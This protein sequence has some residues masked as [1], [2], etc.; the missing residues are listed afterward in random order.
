MTTVPTATGA[1]AGDELGV[2]LMHE[3]VFVLDDALERDL[4]HPEWDEEA[5]IEAATATF[6][7]LAA[8]GVGT[9]VDLTVPGLGRD[10]ARVRRV[11]SRSPVAIV[12]ATGWY[13]R[14]DLPPFFGTHGPGRLVGGADPLEAL[15]VRD[16][17]EGIAGTGVRAAVIKVV[18]DEPGLTPDVTRVLDAAAA[19]HVR[20]GAP[21]MTHSHAPTRGGLAQQEALAA[22]GVDLGRVVIGHAGD[23][24]DLDYLRM[25]ADR[26]SFLGFD[27]FGMAH[28]QSDDARVRTLLALLERGYAESIVLS[29]DAA[30]FS[31][32]TPP[33][34]RARETPDWRMDHLATRIVPRLRAAGV[35]DA[36]MR[37][38]QVDNPRRI[39]AGR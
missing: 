25:L 15:F 1:V 35:D 10:V 19:A 32:V 17:E 4:P 7:R 28:T 38:M 26:G 30:V 23:S 2:T 14:G 5:A 12:V 36:T 37:T 8:L 33:S 24:E 11:A 16:L 22:R 27:R 18:S 13:V 29:H 39:L 34:W 31:R 20:T 6:A 3:H 21:I 9:V